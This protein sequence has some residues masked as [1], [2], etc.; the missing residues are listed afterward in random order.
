MVDQSLSAHEAR[1]TGILQDEGN[2]EEQGEEAGAC[3]GAD[4][5]PVGQSLADSYGAD[6]EQVMEWFCEGG[7]GFGEIMLALKTSEQ[8]E[9]CPLEDEDCS[10]EALLELKTDW[11]L[12]V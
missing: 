12:Y 2:G 1:L 11:G 9:E 5:H 7:Y 8:M 4:P 6:Y 10:P 3:V